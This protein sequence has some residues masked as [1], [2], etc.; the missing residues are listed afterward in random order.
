MARNN[1]K[2]GKKRILTHSEEFEIMKLV[3]DKF[4]WLGMFLLLIGIYLSI[5]K[6]FSNGLWFIIAGALVMLVFAFIIIKEFE[7]M[8]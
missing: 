2:K 1:L 3:L 4:L 6:A 8:R 5:S 7:R